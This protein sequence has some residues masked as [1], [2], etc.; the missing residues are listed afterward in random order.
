MSKVESAIPQSSAS[1][2][3]CCAHVQAMLLMKVGGKE[4]QLVLVERAVWWDTHNFSNVAWS[5]KWVGWIGVLSCVTVFLSP[6]LLCHVSAISGVLSYFHQV[7]KARD[8]SHDRDATRLACDPCY[9]HPSSYGTCFLPAVHPAVSSY[10]LL[11]A[12]L[13]S[14]L[15]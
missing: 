8:V 13:S 5:C 9:N 15:G 12:R 6:W 10:Q 1:K 7:Q 14:R 11:S 3:I 2:E 4:K